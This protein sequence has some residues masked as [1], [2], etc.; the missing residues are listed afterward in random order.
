MNVEKLYDL[1]WTFSTEIDVHEIAEKTQRLRETLQ[2]LANQP[3]NAGHQQALAKARDSLVKSL[4][5]LPSNQLPQSMVESAQEMGV[6][7]HTGG[8]LARRIGRALDGNQITPSSALD[9]LQVVLDEFDKIS[10]ALEGMRSALELFNVTTADVGEGEC[11]IALQVPRG[12]VE[13]SAESLF[14]EWQEIVER[15]GVFSELVTGAR[16]PFAVKSVSSSDFT[17]VLETV[18]EVG[19]YIAVAIERLVALYKK[20][21]DI[22]KVRSELKALEGASDSTL[23]SLGE[24]ANRVAS[25]GVEEVASEVLAAMEEDSACFDRSNDARANELRNELTMALRRIAD[26][27]D[28]G[29][30]LEVAIGA[31]E[32]SGVEGEAAD[33]G[34]ASVRRGVSAVQCT[35]YPKISGEP[36]L[37]LGARDNNEDDDGPVKGGAE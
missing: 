15:L 7:D 37:Q 28:R 1:V 9:A 26:R 29:V 31:S 17:V 11:E 22:R 2:T 23:E 14:E 33:H 20:V 13:K 34:E 6:W 18:P 32:E 5:G 24:D 35:S 25:Q 19:A 30:R 10:S 36:I 27:I 21:L 12:L 8:R 3:Q 4:K 16:R